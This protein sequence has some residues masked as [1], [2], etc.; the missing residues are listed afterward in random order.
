MRSKT[1][2]LLGLALGCGFV[3]SIGIS[4]ILQRQDQTPAGDT[5]PVWVVLTDIKRS[6]PLSMQNLKLEQW[7]K[8]KI[9]PGALSKLEE[10][11]GK[12]A[13]VAMYAGEAVLDKKLLGKEG[14]DASNE[15]PPGFRLFT[16]SAD[17]ISSHGGLL[18]PDD[19]VDVMLY[20]AKGGGIAT[21]G[22]KTILED[23]LVFAV[24]DQIRTTDDKATDS[25]NA[26][27]VTLL[28]TPGQAEK[29]ALA[30]QIGKINLVVRGPADKGT[31]NPNG[32]TLSDLLI[33]EKTDRKA[34]EMDH[35]PVNP[36]AGLTAMLNQA[37]QPAPAVQPTTPEPKPEPVAPQE[38]F[39]IQVI[40]GT[41][42]SVV[43]FKKS[44]DDPTRWENGSSTSVGNL[45]PSASEAEQPPPDD[46]KP[47]TDKTNGNK[48]PGATDAKPAAPDQGASQ[49]TGHS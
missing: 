38:T 33:T 3:A 32:T 41:E 5:A 1:V 29:L 11:D 36:K 22:T 13:K 2:I 10:V 20:I 15:I 9:P 17:G 39:A 19:R 35:P 45:A 49:S 48:A 23:I 27:T 37:Q 42:V 14:Q 4:Q 21:T 16:V 28:V 12:R 7:P 40:R 46:M 8:E 6:D 31:S 26:K 18:H 24:N 25:I 30:N 47:S 44:M 43:D 34:E